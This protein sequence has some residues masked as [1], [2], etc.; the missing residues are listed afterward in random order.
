METVTSPSFRG[1]VGHEKF[2]FLKRRKDWDLADRNVRNSQ[3]F[4]P[5]IKER[6][7]FGV[8]LEK[9]GAQSARESNLHAT[10]E[11][12]DQTVFRE[13]DL[14]A[15]VKKVAEMRQNDPLRRTTEQNLRRIHENTRAKIY[16]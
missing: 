5:Y 1:S 15:H 10:Y 7:D 13:L 14:N 3:A 12:E 4:V 2:S 11:S 9:D 8:I 16:N 6:D